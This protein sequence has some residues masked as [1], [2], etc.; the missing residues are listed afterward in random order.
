MEKKEDLVTIITLN[1][2]NQFLKD[3]IDSVLSQTYGSIQFVLLDDGSEKFNSDQIKRY[4]NCHKK[5]NLKEFI[6]LKNEKNIGTVKSANK[7]YSYA[8]GKY[9][10]NLAG[11]D[12]FYDSDVI[13]DWVNCFIETGGQVITAYRAVYDEKLEKEINVL[14][15]EK[16]VFL[17]KHGTTKQIWD[18]L[19]EKNF[20]F[21]CSTART[22]EYYQ[23]SGGYSE[24]Y[25]YIED[26]PW[27]LKV[28]R[29]GTQ[30]IFWNRIVL[31]YRT[32]G[33]SSPSKFD[34]AYLKDS[35]VVL[36]K[37]I[38]QYSKHK[39]KDVKDLARWMYWHIRLKYKI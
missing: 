6:V 13:R 4:I 37:E 10:F 21:G 26:Y 18:A 38:L 24:T 32:G 17:L 27:N 35:I 30:I 12:V 39:K 19:C 14:P 8:K 11:D 25:K 9:I 20:I 23:K 33:K 7:A 34:I 15:E 28:I 2:N 29:H 31:K 5:E 3:A 22:K 36:I 1:Y 16:D